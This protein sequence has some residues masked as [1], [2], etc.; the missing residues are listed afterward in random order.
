MVASGK[1][2][3]SQ[4]NYSEDVFADDVIHLVVLLLKDQWFK[5]YDLIMPQNNRL[6]IVM[7]TSIAKGIKQSCAEES[8]EKTELIKYQPYLPN[9]HWICLA[10]GHIQSFCEAFAVFHSNLSIFLYL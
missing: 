7:K 5:K 1:R 2:T 9:Q 10:Q 8:E 6:V 4:D 3:D